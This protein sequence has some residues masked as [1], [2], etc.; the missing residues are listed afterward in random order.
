MTDK[1]RLTTDEIMDIL[2]CITSDHPKYPRV[3][4]QTVAH[5]RAHYRPQLAAI[6]LYPAQIPAFRQRFAHLYTTSHVAPGQCVGILSAQSIGEK[7]TQ[8][9]LNSFHSAGIGVAEVITGVPRFREMINATQNP[10]SVVTRIYLDSAHIDNTNFQCVWELVHQHVLSQ[11]VGTVLERYRI[12]HSRRRPWYGVMAFQRQCAEW[13]L[14]AYDKAVVLRVRMPLLYKTRTTLAYIADTLTGTLDG[15][16]VIDSP[17][18]FA[19]VDVHYASGQYTVAQIMKK[20]RAVQLSGIAGLSNAY[21]CKE[22]DAS[23]P[24]KWCVDAVGGNMWKLMAQPWVDRRRTLSNHMWEIITV[25]GV[26]AARGFLIDEFKQTIAGDGYMNAQHIQLLVDVMTHS[27][28]ILSVSRFGLAKSSA[29]P[30]TR[31]SFEQSMDTYLS[32]ALYGESEKTVGA[33]ACI[34][35]GKPTPGGTGC[36]DLMFDGSVSSSS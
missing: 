33:S 25:L 14:S 5:L 30:L 26:E 21:Y 15:V 22:P 31:S 35:L 12:T 10:K 34:M 9:T 28:T 24:T 16:V 8:A 13:D 4:E 29:G 32:A 19:Q 11:T 6:E 7:A 18:E 36:C 17:L 27:G 20:I 23:V 1:R 2:S 3:A